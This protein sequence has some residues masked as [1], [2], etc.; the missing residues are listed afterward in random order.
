[1]PQ[2]LICWIGHT[3]LKCSR[4]PTQQGL[5]PVGQ[6]LADGKY[7]EV[8]LLANYA[9]KETEEYVEF[10]KSLSEAKLVRHQVSLTSP[11]DFDEVYLRAI[12]VIRT[13]KHDHPAAELTYH[14]SPGTSVMAAVWIIL[15]GSLHPA[16]LIN[17][18]LERGVEELKVPLS[19]AS[20]YVPDVLAQ[21][22]E[23]D[24]K[25]A[26]FAESRPQLRAAFSDICYQSPE[27]ELLVSRAAKVAPRS[28][29]VLLQG[30]S[31]TGKELL[32]RAIHEASKR[33][34]KFVAV[35][36]GAI[37][38]NLVESE[39]FGHK[40]GAFT[41]ADKDRD[42]YIQ[43]ADGGTLFLDEL[44]EMP[45]YVQVKL[46]RVIQD[47]KV[48]RV[49]D[50]RPKNVDLRIVSATNRDLHR[51]VLK[52]RFREDLY[53]RL[54]VIVFQI[55]PLRERSGDL[56]FLIDHILDDANCNFSSEPG[57][58]AKSLSVAARRLLLSQRWPGNYRELTNVIMRAMFWCT[59]DTIDVQNVRDSMLPSGDAE[60]ILGRVL[61]ETFDLEEV[62]N[63]VRQHYFS[64][65]WEQTGGVKT[66]AA[67]LLG[68]NNYQTMDNYR[69]KLDLAD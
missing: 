37:P 2:I 46:L 22:Q 67:E 3:D 17:S 33:Q 65:A 34:G 21:A 10:A 27:M 12:E 20:E 26:E 66:R 32:A 39:L 58:T 60:Q 53:H 42:G 4:F 57:F 5:G 64:R 18:S 35:N 13:V 54:A 68:F 23:T 51:E 47:G 15:S 11:M 1:M 45:L 25:L 16:R 41:G 44:G 59:G 49:G 24:E 14:V 8:H 31:G 30:E 36:C 43:D 63:E 40:K 19:I 55:P 6:A 38:E 28:L 56:G 62:L 52:D 29:S 50:T 69:N 61:D 9:P 48:T 7:D